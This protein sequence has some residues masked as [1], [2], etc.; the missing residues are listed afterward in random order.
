MDSWSYHSR[1]TTHTLKSIY[2]TAG[3]IPAISTVTLMSAQSTAITTSLL[4]ISKI[5]WSH[6]LGSQTNK[7]CSVVAFGAPCALSGNVPLPTAPNTLSPLLRSCMCRIQKNLCTLSAG[8]ANLLIT[9]RKGPGS[10][11]LAAESPTVKALR[12]ISGYQC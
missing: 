11:G 5:L 3:T 7:T 4:T 6:A 10:C 12:F 9:Y 1:C 8:I 2:W